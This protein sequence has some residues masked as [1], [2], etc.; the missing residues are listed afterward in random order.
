MEIVLLLL[1]LLVGGVGMWIHANR[2]LAADPHDNGPYNLYRLIIFG[3][4]FVAGLIAPRICLLSAAA[5]FVLQPIVGTRILPPDPLLPLGYVILGFLC[6]CGAWLGQVT[7]VG[8]AAVR[9]RR[10]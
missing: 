3:V 7:A 8:I 1:L 2:V 9:N 4:A 10:G 5:L 6:L